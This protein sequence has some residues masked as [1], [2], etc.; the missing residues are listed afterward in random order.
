MSTEDELRQASEIADAKLGVAEDLGWVI[1]TLTGL[2][3]YLAWNSW[4]MGIPLAAG[5]YVL[6]T[7]KYRRESATAEDCYY[8]AAGLGKYALR[9]TSEA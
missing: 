4:L 5:A 8:R 7:Y 9:N 1:A 3:A 2:S 6:A